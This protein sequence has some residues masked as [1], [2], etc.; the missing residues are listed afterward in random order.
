MK[1]INDNFQPNL[2]E[3]TYNNTVTV[4][5][6]V[7]YGATENYTGVNPITAAKASQCSKAMYQSSFSSEAKA[8]LSKCINTEFAFLKKI[9]FIDEMDKTPKEIYISYFSKIKET[10][11]ECKGFINNDNHTSAF[12]LLNP[13]TPYLKEFFAN[14][15]AQYVYAVCCMGQGG[16][17]HQREAKKYLQLSAN[18]K[19]PPALFEIAKSFEESGNKIKSFEF[20]KLSADGGHLEAQYK[21]FYCHLMGLGTPISNKKAFDYCKLAA[22]RGHSLAQLELAILHKEGMGV[23]AQPELAFVYF[24]KCFD[25]NKLSVKL[26]LELAECYC[27]GVGTLKNLDEAFNCFKLTEDLIKVDAKTTNSEI[28]FLYYNLGLFYEKGRGTKINLEKAFKYYKIAAHHGNA[29]T[30]YQTAQKYE[31]GKMAPKS[32]EKAFKYYKAA[33]F[34]S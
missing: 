9:N 16:I 10:V 20:Y 5:D 22:D 34:K 28:V 8:Y 3:I 2:S 12:N 27:R 29:Q 11:A 19:F 13:L 15:E 32:H 14:Y 31:Y 25:E 24:K 23:K 1:R 6:L 33:A 7:L 4:M 18:Q 30:L 21:M 17:S 26:L